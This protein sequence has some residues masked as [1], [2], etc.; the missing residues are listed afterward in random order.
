MSVLANRSVTQFT[1]V[2]IVFRSNPEDQD[3]EQRPTEAKKLG[4]NGDSGQKQRSNDSANRQQQPF[5]ERTQMIELCDHIEVY[6]DYNDQADSENE[7]SKRPID[8][9]ELDPDETIGG[10]A[11]AQEDLEHS[12]IEPLIG[13]SQQP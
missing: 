13:D 11:S 2:P 4:S 8:N 6:T 12:T 10:Y 9:F 7:E 5:V 1:T 3:N